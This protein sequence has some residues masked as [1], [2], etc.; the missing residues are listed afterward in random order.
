MASIL[1]C[2]FLK[3]TSLKLVEARTYAVGC[4]IDERPGVVI[5]E[6]SFFVEKKCLMVSK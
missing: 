1:P 2:I 3:H 6:L 4:P 5:S